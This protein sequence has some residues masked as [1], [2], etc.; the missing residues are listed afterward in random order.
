MHHR[1][2]HLSYAE[3]TQSGR[4][5]PPAPNRTSNL[6]YLQLHFTDPSQTGTPFRENQELPL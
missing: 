6:S 5:I 3:S 4:L 2:L 1:L